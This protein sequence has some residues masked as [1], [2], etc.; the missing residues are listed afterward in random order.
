MT[1]LVDLIYSSL[2]FILLLPTNFPTPGF[3]ENTHY[4][5]W[6]EP[7]QEFRFTKMEQ[8]CTSLKYLEYM[9][10]DFEGE[11]GIFYIKT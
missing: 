10:R 4:R 7:T 1:E 2:F 9:I 3:T 11:S 5:Y 8:F 6:R